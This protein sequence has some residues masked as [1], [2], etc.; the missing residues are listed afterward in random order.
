MFIIVIWLFF[1]VVGKFITSG[2]ILFKTKERR[3]TNLTIQGNLTCVTH[4]SRLKVVTRYEDVH[5]MHVAWRQ[6]VSLGISDISAEFQEKNLGA[7]DSFLVSN[8]C[9]YPIALITC[10]YFEIILFV[11]TVKVKC[12]I[13]AC[14]VACNKKQE[15]RINFWWLRFIALKNTPDGT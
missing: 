12:D 8:V 10:C 3:T 9:N 1:L 11:S 6:I 13:W 2:T 14:P 7:R 5:T 4:G 15:W